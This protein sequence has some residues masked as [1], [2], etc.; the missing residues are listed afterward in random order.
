MSLESNLDTPLAAAVRV[1]GSQSAFGRLIGRRQSTVRDWLR[2][3]K[4]LPGEYVLDVERQT[5]VSRHAL[6]P[7]L[8]P[9]SEVDQASVAD[10]NQPDLFACDGVA[11][12]PPVHDAVVSAAAPIVACDRS[13]ILHPEADHG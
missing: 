12:V 3:G 13:G 5:G 11:P 2:L 6:R 1:A 4:P 9:V 7:D 8:Y 10:A